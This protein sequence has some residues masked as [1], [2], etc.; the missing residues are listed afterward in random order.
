MIALLN[1]FY[2]GISRSHWWLCQVAIVV[3]FFVGLAVT[4]FLFA[5]PGSPPAHRNPGETI[6]LA[7]VIVGVLYMNFSTCL[8]R[9]YN[10]GRSWV[11]YLT[12][13]LPTVGLGLML[14]FCGIEAGSGRMTRRRNRSE[15][16]VRPPQPIPSRQPPKTPQKQTG[17]GRRGLSNTR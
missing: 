15:P 16:N 3:A 10:S 5:T 4:A 17:F 7:L 6:G 14:Y 1:P 8:N 13:L 2:G 9:L 11:W 12:F